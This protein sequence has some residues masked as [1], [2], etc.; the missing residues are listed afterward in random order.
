MGDAVLA[1]TIENLCCM[2]PERIHF[3]TGRLAEFALRA[4]LERFRARSALPTASR[5]CRLPWRRL[6]S[7]DWVAR[8]VAGPVAADR[9]VLPGYC[10]GDLAPIAAALGVPVERGPHDLRGW[11]NFLARPPSAGRLRPVRHRDPGRDQSRP[12]ADAWPRSWR[13]PPHLRAAGAD[14]IDVG[15]DPGEPGQASGRPCAPLRRRRDIAFR[16]TA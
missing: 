12:A 14:L 9:A 4:E 7:T 2:P 1:R 3:I 8:H 11:A 13:R 5:C 10:H 6:M 15:C 16:S